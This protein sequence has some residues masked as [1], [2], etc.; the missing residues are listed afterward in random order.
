M[1]ISKIAACLLFAAAVVSS[2]K[3]TEANYRAAYE[4]AVAGRDSLT[5]LE[6]TIYG[7]HRRNASASVAVL[8]NDTIEV[9]STRVAVTDGGGGIRENL[10]PYSLVVGQF[11]Q[12]VNAKSLRERLVDAGY[13]KTFVVNTAEPYYYIILDSFATREE[14]LKAC[15][16]LRH[17]KSF[18]IAMRDGLPLVLNVPR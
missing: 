12:I 15:V 6:N 3:T 18:P 8:G 16:S 9:L 4:K 1:K 14:A 13:P 17:D 10:K 7:R 5:P 11:K 2:C